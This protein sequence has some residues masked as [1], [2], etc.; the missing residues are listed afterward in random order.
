MPKAVD[1]LSA[2]RK[3]NNITQEQIGKYLG[4]SKQTV[5]AWETCTRKLPLEQAIEWASLL[6]VPLAEL[7]T[8][9][10]KET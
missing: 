3:A 5:S 9:T 1:F 8:S 4:V 2:A 10:R 6:D 7:L